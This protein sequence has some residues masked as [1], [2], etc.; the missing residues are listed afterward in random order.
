M[1]GEDL[2]KA[3]MHVS[4]QKEMMTMMEDGI[5]EA[6]KINRDLMKMDMG[7]DLDFSPRNRFY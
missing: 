6:D 2:S 5:L 4:H 1:I 7:S 3:A